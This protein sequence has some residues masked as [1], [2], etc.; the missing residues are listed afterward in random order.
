MSSCLLF[1]VIPFMFS[2]ERIYVRATEVGFLFYFYQAPLEDDLDAEFRLLKE[3]TGSY[4]MAL[5]YCFSSLQ[6][7]ALLQ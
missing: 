5:K 4:P 6:S 7:I 2:E 3:S 1:L